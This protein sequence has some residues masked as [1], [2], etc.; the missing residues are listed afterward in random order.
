MPDRIDPPMKAYAKLHIP[1]RLISAGRGPAVL[2]Y[3]A[4]FNVRDGVKLA[5]RKLVSWIR[6]LT[7]TS[8][9][10]R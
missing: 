4:F 5:R 6:N 7:L 8:K 2:G 9:T 10:S 1:E 3:R